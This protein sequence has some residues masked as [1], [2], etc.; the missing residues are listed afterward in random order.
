MKP[1]KPVESIGVRFGASGHPLIS[2][3]L[4]TAKGIPRSRYVHPEVSLSANGA[5]ALELEAEEVGGICWRW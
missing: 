1:G 4:I 5:G 3:V 2:S